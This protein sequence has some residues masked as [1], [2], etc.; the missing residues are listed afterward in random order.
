MA[1]T[2]T[3]SSQNL[4]EEVMR[5][6]PSQLQPTFGRYAEIPY[7]QMT[8]QQQEGYHSLVA[9]EGRAPG[10]R[11]PGP[12]KIWVNN[13]NL[14]TAMAPLASHF[15]PSHH[16]LTERERELTVC[17][18]N[19]KWHT[20]YSIDFHEMTAKKLGLPPEMIDKVISGLP[21]SFTDEREQVIYELATTLANS[22]WVPRGLYDRAVKALGQNGITDVIVLMGYYTAVSL[23]L[24]FYDVPA[25]ALGMS[26][27]QG[28]EENK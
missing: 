26:M 10:S 21:A 19:S 1:Q 6:D 17:I 23:T 22:R 28:K 16:S 2:T 11:L 8:P 20:P 13:P 12:L 5:T 15:E 3:R 24:A 14:S 7:D 25:G 4:S 27:A 9:A 18:I